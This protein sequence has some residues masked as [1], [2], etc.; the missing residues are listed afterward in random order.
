MLELIAAPDL[1]LGAHGRLLDPFEDGEVRGFE[2]AHPRPDNGEW[3]SGYAPC[4]PARLEDWE[5][6]SRD[7]ITLSPSL[8][9]RICGHHGFVIDGRWVSA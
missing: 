2:Y 5:L 9:C 6:V 3:C 1:G 7:P 8:L 4:S